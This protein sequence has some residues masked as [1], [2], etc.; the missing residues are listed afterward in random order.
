MSFTDPLY[1]LFL[2]G[3]FLLYYMLEGGLPRRVLLLAA[4][5]YF[6]FELSGMYLLVL[7]LVTAVTYYGALAI[8]RTKR[9]GFEIFLLV[10]TL[11]LIPL[12]VF[13]YLGAL[14]AYG[15][16]PPVNSW[17]GELVALTMPI[18]ISFF[19]FAALGYLI[20]VYLEVVEPESDFGKVAL[21]LA[22]FPLVS[23]GPIERAGRFMSQFDLT[24]RFSASQALSALR[25][26]L[27]GLVLKMIFADILQKPSDNMFAAPGSWPPIMRLIGLIDF[28]FYLYADFAGYSLIAIGSAR[29]LGLEVKP[30]FTQPFLSAT[31]PEFWRNWHISLSSWVRDYIFAPLRTQWRHY[32]RAGLAAALMISIVT[33]GVWHGPKWGFLLFGLMHG[34]F[35]TTSAF[36]LA[37]RDKW[38]KALGFSPAI[39][40]TVRM[41]ITFAL[42]LTTFVVFR[43][44]TLRDALVV[45]QGLF[46]LELWRNLY[47]IIAWTG[48]HHGTPLILAGALYKPSALIPIIIAGDILVR[49][50]IT[51]EKFPAPLQAAFYGLAIV[52]VIGAWMAVYVPQPFVYNKF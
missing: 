23:A 33:I 8:R 27:I 26:I 38:C 3:V 10:F 24:S 9:R 20:D 29:L 36:T 7:F 40:F 44:N 19:T 4:S 34:I 25:L 22:F 13:K 37:Q 2:G 46:S 14:L 18:G 42:V 47:Q 52:E 51:L 32:P 28:A 15:G 16:I 6:Y 41:I 31:V 30:N 21:F 17:R 43:A 12:L 35:V 11:S 48:F 39:V 45:Y 5:Y 1:Y 49:K 50:K